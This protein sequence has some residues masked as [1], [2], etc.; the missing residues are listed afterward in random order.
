MSSIMRRRN[1]LIA[2]AVMGRLLFGGRVATP[3]LQTGRTSYLSPRRALGGG[4]LPRE[5]FSPMTHSG[6]QGRA[7]NPPPA[8]APIRQPRSD[9]VCFF[10]GAIERAEHGYRIEVLN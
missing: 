2:W 9:V 10:A 4:A 8:R 7:K 6:P 1:G 5:R 3:H